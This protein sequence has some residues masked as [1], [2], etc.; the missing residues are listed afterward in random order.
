MF[1]PDVSNETITGV[2]RTA[3][4]Y[5]AFGNPQFTEASASIEGVSVQPELSQ[6][7][8]ST[9]DQV[10][11]QW[12]LFGPYGLALDTYDYVIHP[13][14]GKLQIDGDLMTH[15]PLGILEGHIEVLLKRWEG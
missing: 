12:R 6:E 14:E 4:G 2:T 9:G 11:T 8:V 1:F 10:V 7:L 13:A 15:P 3:S 5:D